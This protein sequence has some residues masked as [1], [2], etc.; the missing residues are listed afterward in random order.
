[1]FVI[2][3][4]KI[5]WIVFSLLTL[6]ATIYFYDGGEFSD[7]W[8]LLTIFMLVLSFPSGIFISLF[9]YFVAS[10]FFVTIETSYLSI[11]LEWS[12]YFLIG[13]LQ[14]FV[15]FPIAWKI[16]RAKLHRWHD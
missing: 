3:T 2:K 14:W 7:V 16:L 10:I 4:L 13:Y 1:M 12:A 9:H 11:F 8:V 5:I 15:V 6:V